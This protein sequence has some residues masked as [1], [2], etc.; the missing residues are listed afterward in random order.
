MNDSALSPSADEPADLSWVA[1]LAF[2]G[3]LLTCLTGWVLLVFMAPKYLAPYL[4]QGVSLPPLSALTLQLSRIAGGAVGMGCALV[5][6]VAVALAWRGALKGRTIATILLI[7]AAAIAAIA[8]A[9]IIY[10]FGQP[11]RNVEDRV[12]EAPAP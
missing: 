10:S 4:E 1:H 12:M 11:Q 5:L 7:V 3:A 6:L 9:T 2:A 8:D